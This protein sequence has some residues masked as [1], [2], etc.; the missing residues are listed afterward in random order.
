MTINII[1]FR[2]TKFSTIAFCITKNKKGDIKYKN[3]EYK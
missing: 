1:T 2:I 3:T